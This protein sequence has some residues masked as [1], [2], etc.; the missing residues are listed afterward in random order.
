MRRVSAA[1]LLI[2][3]LPAC[4]GGGHGAASVSRAT[5]VRAFVRSAHLTQSVSID[6]GA[7]R[8]DPVAGAPRMAEDGLLRWRVRVQAR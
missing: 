6:D 4:S 8:L 5:D 7:L 2:A 3:A 1:G